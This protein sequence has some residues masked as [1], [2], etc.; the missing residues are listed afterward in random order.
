MIKVLILAYDFPPYVSVGA[1]RPYYWYKYFREFGINPVVVSRQWN[2]NF[3]GASQ[4]VAEG[5]S[6]EDVI[7]ETEYGVLLKTP[8]K[9]NLANRLYLKYGEKR[10]RLLRKL[11][12]GYYEVLQ[13]YLPIGPKI[14]IFRIANTFLKENKVDIIIATG[15]PFILFKYASQLS[16]KYGVPWIAD[17]RDPCI[18]NVNAKLIF[19]SLLNK[20][21]SINERKYIKSASYVT[22]VSAFFAELIAKNN[23][24]NKYAIIPN[25]FDSDAIEEVKSMRQNAECFTITYI[26]RIYKYYPID[27]FF[28]VLNNFIKNNSYARFQLQL[29]GVSGEFNKQ[30]FE[31]KY[32]EVFAKTL[33]LP[34]LQISDLLKHL[35]ASNI[36]LLFNMYSIIGTKIYDYISINRKILMCYS[37]DSNALELKNHYFTVKDNCK[38]DLRAQ[39]KLILDK[40]A[41]IIVKNK[42]HLLEVLN[43]LYKEFSETG[44]VTCHSKDISEYSRKAQTEKLATLIKEI[45]EKPMV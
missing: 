27:S 15:D 7:K 38:M 43:D 16:K 10:F 39:E 20:I 5:Y 1:Q 25:G 30:H 21:N 17:Y 11:I 23:T 40:N 29:I 42:E 3:I 14:G 28:S 19:S 36:L 8:Y 26:G 9:P 32:P 45:V 33:I 44:Q 12:S 22:I 41:G 4:Y 37:N 13:W 18:Q 2:N 6:N 24:G 35:A 31:T 34:P